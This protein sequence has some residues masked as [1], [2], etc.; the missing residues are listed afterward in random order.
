[1]TNNGNSPRNIF[2]RLIVLTVAVGVVTLVAHWSGGALRGASGNDATQTLAVYDEKDAP[3]QDAANGDAASAGQKSAASTESAAGAGVPAPYEVIEQSDMVAGDSEDA[4]GQTNKAGEEHLTIPDGANYVPNEVLV[5]VS[6]DATVE[7]VNALIAQTNSVVAREVS[8]EE[9]ENGYIKLEVSEGAS[10]EDAMNDLADSTVTEDAQPN[11]IYYAML[12]DEG[13]LRQRLD[14]TLAPQAVEPQDAVEEDQTTNESEGDDTTQETSE[15]AV[16]EDNDNS[17]EADGEDESSETPSD[18]DAAAQNDETAAEKGDGESGLTA[19]ADDLVKPNDERLESQWALASMHV[20]EAWALAKCEHTVAVAIVDQGPDPS[21]YDLADNVVDTYDAVENDESISFANNHGTAVSGI[22]SA[23]ADNEIGIAGVSYNADLVLINAMKPNLSTT[24]DYL[25][26]AITYAANNADTYNIRVLNISVGGAIKESIESMNDGTLKRAIDKVNA[27]GIVTVAAAGNS[28]SR[29]SDNTTAS[30]PFYEY[31]GDFENVV[32]VINLK[33]STS[34]TN[35]L[36]NPASGVDKASGSNY[37]VEG[38]TAKNISAPG[39]SILSTYSDSNS[40]ASS[41]SGT[42]MAAP[43][44]TGVLALEFAANPQLSA[45][46]AVEI[47]YGTAYESSTASD[48]LYDPNKSLEENYTYFG[49]GEVNAFEA[50]KVAKG[51]EAAEELPD[52]SGLEVPV[53]KIVGATRIPVG[54]TASYTVTDGSIEVKSGGTYASLEN[55]TL[56]G[57]KKGTVTL[58]VLDKLGRERSTYDVSVYGTEGTWIIASKLDSTYVIDVQGA[59][60]ENGGNAILY[61]SNGKNNQVWLLE[62]QGDGSF[63]IRSGK[64]GKVLDVSGGSASNG[65]NVCQYALGSKAWQRWTMQVASDNSIVFVN[66]N[67]EMALE[68][69]GDSAANCKNVRQATMTD[70]GRQR[71]VLRGVKADMGSVWDG[72][73]RVSSSADRNY[74]LEVQQRS[75]ANGA[76]VEIYR[77]N[78]GA[79]QRWKVEYLGKDVYR[80]TNV[81]SLLSL[82][83]QGAKT[84]NSVNIDQWPWK[85]AGNQRW[86]FT[87]YADGS[88]AIARAGT[89]WVVDVKGGIAKNG[90][91]VHQYT[92]KNNSAQKWF[93]TQF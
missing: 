60:I 41:L 55:N 17:G 15:E 35:R 74:V 8:A 53:P 14:E 4:T 81:N 33:Q 43:Q 67:S 73:Y 10:V 52:I 85:N 50:V 32:S 56:T 46:E 7:E 54:A 1:M 88:Y 42:S 30:V 61:Q 71:W 66:K 48:G 37:N 75:T 5:A 44:V 38:Q 11:Y 92:R 91:N 82:D 40:Y 24:S 12:G 80:I 28:G 19:L 58:A 47:L 89:S 77:W 18:S 6:A 93:L 57:L 72:I 83:V 29:Y 59:S 86:N 36:S 68:I 51:E 45:A 21:H 2:V 63:V 65:A 20:Y 62:N 70:T 39:T 64:S 31:P 22:V 69:D 13:D 23:V 3:I 27:K 84:G 34:T 9:I 87:K 79:H 76:N 90:T 26:K 16:P 78:G 25:S 49:W